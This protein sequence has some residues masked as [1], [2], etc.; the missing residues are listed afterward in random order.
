MGTFILKR[1][2][3][4]ETADP[5]FLGKASSMGKGLLKTA[6]SGLGVSTAVDEVKNN[7]IDRPLNAMAEEAS[8]YVPTVKNAYVPQQKSYGLVQAAKEIG[9]GVGKGLMNWGKKNQGQL[10]GLAG[11]GA[12]MSASGYAVNRVNR[13]KDEI[14]SGQRE[15]TGLS[16]GEK[17]A[18]GTSALGAGAGVAY[19]TGKSHDKQ[20]SKLNETVNKSKS[21]YTEAIKGA[22]SQMNNLDKVDK[23]GRTGSDRISQLD[24][25]A[26]KAN[27][28]RINA[29]NTITNM[30]RK[31]LGG[32]VSNRSFKMGR[33][34]LLAGG[35]ITGAGLLANK[36]LS[37]GPEQKEYSKWGAVKKIVGNVYN[38]SIQSAGSNAGFV[39]K[40]KAGAQAL[41]AGVQ[42]G[43]KVIA[44]GASNFF[45]PGKGGA[46]GIMKEVRSELK[47]TGDYGKAASNFIK[48][49][50]TV[51]GVGT[52]ATLGSAAFNAANAAGEKPVQA[53][54][55]IMDKKT[56]DYVKSREEE[57]NV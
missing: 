31:R 24:N 25:I 8:T 53:V 20:I 38:K 6:S 57:Y 49:H 21:R 3:Y 40:A 55:N 16:T 28:D 18:A 2:Y 42:V 44:R 30:N 34:A 10:K 33:N 15:A 48:N 29:S 12:A 22:Q 43:S 1:R 37:K 36:V 35:L 47:N 52:A 17:I 32:L 56:A 54:T 4:N 11:F 9:T 7:L 14:E 19:A 51:V 46:G 5:S 39:D 27:A 45:T 23:F 26:K 41:G 13:K 50:K